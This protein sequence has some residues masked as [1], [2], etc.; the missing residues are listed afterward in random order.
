[1]HTTSHHQYQ[2]WE[3]AGGE[4]TKG[5]NQHTRSMALLPD[6][7]LILLLDHETHLLTK[8]N[9]YNGLPLLLS[10]ATLA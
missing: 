2:H 6:V 5:A 7:L 10:K 3:L 4:N 8:L 1:M 9:I